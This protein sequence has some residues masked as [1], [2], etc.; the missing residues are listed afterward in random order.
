MLKNTIKSSGGCIPSMLLIENC[1]L[2]KREGSIILVPVE[3]LVK[4]NWQDVND[5][6]SFQCETK[7]GEQFA[8]IVRKRH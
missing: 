4:L 1:K 2:R 3:E 7:D 8:K 5:N 6:I